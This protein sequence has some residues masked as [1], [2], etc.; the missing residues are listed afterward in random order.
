[1][2]KPKET[3]HVEMD[4]VMEASGLKAHFPLASWPSSS[5]VCFNCPV[6]ICRLPLV[7]STSWLQRSRRERRKGRPTLLFSASSKSV[8]RYFRLRLVTLSFRFLP[9]LCTEHM[10]VSGKSAGKG[11]AEKVLSAVV[12][13]ATRQFNCVG[14][15]Q[16]LGPS[17]VD[18]SV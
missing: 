17:F 1:M 15:G 6:I 7:R 16:A 13:V 8:G 12:L 5:A 2:T 4:V 3:V 11:T 18:S 14:S 9:P 10:A